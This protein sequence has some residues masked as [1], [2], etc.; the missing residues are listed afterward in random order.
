MELKKIGDKYYDLETNEEMTWQKIAKLTG[1]PRGEAR[2]LMK[3]LAQARRKIEPSELLEW[4]ELGKQ[5]W[6]LERHLEAS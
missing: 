6:K 2:I 5:I 1:L 4:R 3:K